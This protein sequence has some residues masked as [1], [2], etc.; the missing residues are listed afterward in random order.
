MVG[1]A[2][3]RAW[4]TRLPLMVPARELRGTYRLMTIVKRFALPD[5]ALRKSGQ[6]HAPNSSREWRSTD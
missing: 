1:A 2:M 5:A 6:P 4:G 3:A